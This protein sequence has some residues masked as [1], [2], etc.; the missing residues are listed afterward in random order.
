MKHRI[1][2]LAFAMTVSISSIFAN[3]NEDVVNYRASSSF[4]KEFTQAQEVKWEKS[5]D[6]SK[7]TFKMNDQLMVA[8][9]N[10]EGVLLGV[11]RNITTSQLPLNLMN[12]VK[13]NYSKTWISDLFEVTTNE[14]TSY[15]ITLE[16]AD[17][18]V[19]LKSNGAYGWS[20]FKKE[21]KDV[22]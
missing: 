18:K 1:L 8:Y 17:Q 15:Y 3:N 11:T 7:A 14:D 19:V 2:T 9:Y 5:K 22:Q 13:K 10:N 21:K 20:T 4:K 16:D 12:D 6:F